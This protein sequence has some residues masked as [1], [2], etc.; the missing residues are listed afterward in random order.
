MKLFMMFLSLSLI[1][2]MAL[3][4][5]GMRE[6]GEFF[7][8]ELNL[9]DEQLEKVREIR[10]ENHPQIKESRAQFKK[11]K[12]EFKEAMKDPKTSS[13]DLMAKFETFQKARDEFHRLRFSA[14][15]KMREI[16][17]PQQIE[18]FQKLKKEH[19]KKKRD[20]KKSESKKS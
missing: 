18:K 6:R 1:S 11:L 17:T 16:M 5:R 4:D 15:L 9:N 10:K 19:R 7:K 20:H 8:K 12:A 2:N 14:M 3:A 13:S